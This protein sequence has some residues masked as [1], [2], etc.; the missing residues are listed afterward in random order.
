MKRYNRLKNIVTA[1]LAATI[2]FLLLVPALPLT[3]KLIGATFFFASVALI[4]GEVD[5][6]MYSKAKEY[7]EKRKAKR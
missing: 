4:I 7:A 6:F 5:A 1:G 2:Y 3:Q